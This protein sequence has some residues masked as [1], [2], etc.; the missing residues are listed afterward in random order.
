MKKSDKE[1]NEFLHYWFI[2]ATIYPIKA[3]DINFSF[4]L[5]KISSFK[6]FNSSIKVCDNKLAIWQ[7]T[8]SGREPIQL[9]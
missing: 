2:Q 9:I 6:I 3:M 7:T 5:L 4:Q 8:T 1:N